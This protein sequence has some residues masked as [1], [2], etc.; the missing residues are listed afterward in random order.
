MKKKPR[1]PG[2]YSKPK[3][4]AK[5]RKPVVE[6]KKTLAKTIL[7]RSVNQPPKQYQETRVVPS[8]YGKRKKRR[9]TYSTPAQTADEL[10][11][12]TVPHNI[13]NYS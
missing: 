1:G 11:L 2:R 5:P 13:V 6:N 9:N 3:V 10:W 4:I 7:G 8:W 12:N